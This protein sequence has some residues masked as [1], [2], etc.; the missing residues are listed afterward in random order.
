M[1]QFRLDDKVEVV[2]GGAK[3]IGATVV[4]I[5]S[6]AGAHVTVFDLDGPDGSASRRRS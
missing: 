3:G 2:T 5:L 1:Q 6:E 4:Q